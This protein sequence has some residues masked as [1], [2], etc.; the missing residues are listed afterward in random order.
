MTM[1]TNDDDNNDEKTSINDGY[2]SEDN[3]Q[4]INK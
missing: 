1:T 4:A 2:D 3:Q